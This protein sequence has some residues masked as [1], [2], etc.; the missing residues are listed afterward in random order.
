MPLK[1]NKLLFLPQ[2]EASLSLS[3]FNTFP[4][5]IAEEREIVKLGP[6]HLTLFSE[7][8]VVFFQVLPNFSPQKGWFVL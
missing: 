8:N 1:M 4:L 6:H 7:L 3:Q 2:C 5:T